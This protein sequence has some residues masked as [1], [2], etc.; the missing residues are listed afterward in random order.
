MNPRTLTQE[1]TLTI[2]NF[3]AASYA[4]HS[5]P[6]PHVRRMWDIPTFFNKPGKGLIFVSIKEETGRIYG[7][8]SGDARA[9]SLIDVRFEVVLGRGTFDVS[10]NW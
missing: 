8:V 2:A 4:A 10:P 5:N 3:C 9:S 6:L 7:L 1:Q